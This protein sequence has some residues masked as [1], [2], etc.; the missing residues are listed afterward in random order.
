[1]QLTKHLNLSYERGSMGGGGAGGR[2]V[3]SYNKSFDQNIWT[4]I[5]WFN[6]NDIES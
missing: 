4:Y 5:Q 6:R 1:M 2:E 3:E